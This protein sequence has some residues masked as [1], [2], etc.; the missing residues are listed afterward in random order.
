MYSPAQ[1]LYCWPYLRVL[2]WSTWCCR[3]V[4][5]SRRWSVLWRACARRYAKKKLLWRWPRHGLKKERGALTS[6]CAKIQPCRGRS[7]FPYSSCDRFSLCFTYRLR[8][9]SASSKTNMLYQ[10]RTPKSLH[11]RP[12]WVWPPASPTFNIMVLEVTKY[13]FLWWISWLSVDCCKMYFK[14][15]YADSA[16]TVVHFHSRFEFQNLFSSESDNSTITQSAQLTVYSFNRKLEFILT[17][18]F[19]ILNCLC[20]C[21]SVMPYRPGFSL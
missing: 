17:H 6:N 15:I 19:N 11:G 13:K 1:G 21:T 4:A 12:I 16:S 14:I 3:R 18:V 9:I 10:R 2:V 8:L 20:M 7:A 5:K